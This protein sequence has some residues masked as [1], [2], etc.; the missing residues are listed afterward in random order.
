MTEYVPGKCNIGKINRLSRFI[1]GVALLAFVLWAFFWM[2]E[3]GFSSFFRLVLF[4]PLYGGFLG[5][6][7]AAVGFCILN[8]EEKKFELR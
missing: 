3:T 1:I 7:Q 8:A 4:F 2:K 5:V 6:T